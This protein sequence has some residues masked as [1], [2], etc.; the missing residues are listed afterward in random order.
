LNPEIRLAS[1]FMYPENLE[2]IVDYLEMVLAPLDLFDF[3]TSIIALSDAAPLY[4]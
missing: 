2:K 4:P 1:P 3:A